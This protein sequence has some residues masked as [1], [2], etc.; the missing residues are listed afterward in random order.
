MHFRHWLIHEVKKRWHY[1]PTFPPGADAAIAL[2]ADVL[3]EAAPARI[4]AT[5]VQAIG[6]E[7][8]YAT[9]PAMHL[10]IDTIVN[11]AVAGL[12][13]EFP[14]TAKEKNDKFDA[15]KYLFPEMPKTAIED[16]K[17]SSI[18]EVSGA[19]YAKQSTPVTMEN[20]IEAV[21]KIEMGKTGLPAAGSMH[22]YGHVLMGHNV[23]EKPKPAA[24]T[25]VQKHV[26]PSPPKRA[27]KK[28]EDA[29]LAQLL[30][31]VEKKADELL[32]IKQDAKKNELLG[33]DP[34]DI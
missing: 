28:S 21:K 7:K 11:V 26:P 3:R 25:Y 8:E 23:A 18:G 2:A 32:G 27:P 30:G 19:G 10:A 5:L 34:E 14:L 33:I 15:L 9:D 16:I 29:A 4:R 1:G 6:A 20:V 12:F 13:G 17:W 31:K 24:K 22:A